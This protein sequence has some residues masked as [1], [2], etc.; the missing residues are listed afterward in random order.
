MET[1]TRDIFLAACTK[2]AE[3][4]AIHGFKPMQ[5]AQTIRKTTRNKKVYLD[6]HFQSSVK[7][8]SGGVML[9][10]YLSIASNELKRWQVQQHREGNATGTIFATRLENLTPLKNKTQDWNMAV[11]NQDNVIPKL[12][13]L[14]VAYTLP[15]VDLLE[16]TDQAVQFMVANGV[17]F[18]EH[19]DTRHQNLPIDFLCCFGSVALA[20]KAFDNYLLQQKLT[21]SAKRFY[22]EIAAKGEVANRVVTDSTMRAA[23]RNKLT[24]NG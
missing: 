24:I 7:N 1:K 13:E 2:I 11:S 9:W 4:L 5:K 15:L 20:Q 22:E 21:A 17:A 14:I 19:F 6:I 12:C 18:N 10:P 23:Y 8:W 16:D 3:Q